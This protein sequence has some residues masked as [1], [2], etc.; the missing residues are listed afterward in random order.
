MIII[1]KPI[2]KEE[3]FK[4]I[5]FLIN[6]EM[7][8]GVVDLKK[9]LIA[10]D[11]PLHADL[12]QNL[13]VAG[14]NHQDLWGINLYKDESDE[15]FIEFD[16]MINLRPSQNNRSRSVEDPDLRQQ[17]IHGELIVS[18]R[19]QKMEFASQMGNIGSEVSRALSAKEKNKDKRMNSAIDRAL[20]LFDSSISACQNFPEDSGKLKELLYAREEFCS[21]FF[22]GTEI[23]VDPIKMQRYYD[24]FVSLIGKE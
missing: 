1:N 16:S 20:E 22:G 6:D 19:W 21:F 24:Q 23:D 15:D 3:L 8:K 4:K 12:E 7:V 13:L 9:Q 11:A 14:S 10:L 17:P 2:S 5:A 18:G